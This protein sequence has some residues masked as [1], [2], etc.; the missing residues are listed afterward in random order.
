[1][2]LDDDDCEELVR[3]ISRWLKPGGKQKRERG[4]GREETASFGVLS[5][6]MSKGYE[7]LNATF[8]KKKKR[9]RNM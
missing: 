5:P 7:K 2:Y 6:K 1:M 3:R 4:E 8:T 9:R